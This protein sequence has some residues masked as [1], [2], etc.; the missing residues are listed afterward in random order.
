MES[1]PARRREPLTFTSCTQSVD[2]RRC[3]W[4]TSVAF[5]CIVVRI[6]PGCWRGGR[7]VRPQTEHVFISYAIPLLGLSW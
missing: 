4:M 5:V 2:P 7:Q 6:V 3:S 1:L